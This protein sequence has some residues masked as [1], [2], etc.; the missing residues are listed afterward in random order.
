[1]TSCQCAIAPITDGSGYPQISRIIQICLWLHG[2]QVHSIIPHKQKSMPLCATFTPNR[3]YSRISP[4]QR[5][6]WFMDVPSVSACCPDTQAYRIK[7]CSAS[8]YYTTDLTATFY[9][10][11]IMRI[12]LS[13]SVSDFQRNIAESLM[14]ISESI[15][16][17]TYTTC[18]HPKHGDQPIFTWV[19]YS[20]NWQCAESNRK[21]NVNT[22]LYPCSV[23][24]PVWSIRKM[25]NGTL[26]SSVLPYLHA[27]V[28][29]AKG[30]YD[31]T[32]KQL[33]VGVAP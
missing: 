14:H 12:R 2:F 22:V 6:K 25:E 23:P 26:V 8:L 17:D 7:R 13:L 18:T 31:G 33:G 32:E 9:G 4:C 21:N 27:L 16:S 28:V 20:W 11:I 1:M 10:N 3:S 5:H 30:K 24:L 19:F 15:P 29:L